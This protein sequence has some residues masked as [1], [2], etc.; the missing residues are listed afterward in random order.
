MA[1][2]VN[3]HAAKNQYAAYAL[4]AGRAEQC[5]DYGKAAELWRRA[6]NAPCNASKQRWAQRRAAFCE[7]AH[8]KG[9]RAHGDECRTV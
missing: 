7:N 5:G 1:M 2:R 3:E 4:G 8:I 6:A 9:W